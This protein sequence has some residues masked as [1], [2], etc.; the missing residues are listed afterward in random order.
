MSE[1]YLRQDQ[2]KLGTL[3]SC[4]DTLAI[5]VDL[6]PYASGF[7]EVELLNGARKLISK[8]YLRGA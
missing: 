4:N 2:I 6:T 3:I 8:N 1:V 7:V 5:V